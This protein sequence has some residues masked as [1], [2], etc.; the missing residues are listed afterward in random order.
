M[1]K[2]N[3]LK[4]RKPDLSYEKL[5][6]AP[7][8]HYLK[9]NALAT[10]FMNAMHVIVPLGETFF[11]QSVKRY[12]DQLKDPE[13]KKEVKAFIGQ[14][15]MHNMEHIKFWEV[16]EAQGFDVSVFR[17]F[18]AKTAFE[19]IQPWL[20]KVFGDKL[21]L[22]TTVALE[23]FTAFGAAN[24]LDPNS[25]MMEGIHEEMAELL[26]WHA[27][28]E[29]EHKSVAFNVLKEV[30]DSYFLRM[31]GFALGGFFLHTYGFIGMAIFASQD[32]QLTPRKFLEDIGQFTMLFSRR[33]ESKAVMKILDY[34][35]PDFHPD[36][37]DHSKILEEHLQYLKTA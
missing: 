12:R 19:Y 4:V 15:Q 33:F 3:T 14:E 2:K 9:G 18:Y 25:D 8:P 27:V 29:I 13:L 10:H 6:K 28:E 26:R 24:A 30:D 16:L 17:D 37:T 20:S 11:I 5:K 31:A 36:D 34:F 35:R 1:K 23:H 32:K 7:S 22:S 21:A